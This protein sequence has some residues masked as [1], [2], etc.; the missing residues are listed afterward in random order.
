VIRIEGGIVVTMDPQRRVIPEG[1]VLLDGSRISAVGDASAGAGEHAHQIVDARGMAVLPG[2]VNSHTHIGSNILARGLL[3]DVMLFQWLDTLWKLKVN[4]THDDLF[5]AS[6]VGIAEMLLSG[7]TTYNEFFDGYDPLPG[8][9]AMGQFGMRAAAG[10][11]VADGGVYADTAEQSWRDIKRMG[12]LKAAHDGQADGRIHLV[13][14]PHAPYT[15]SKDLYRETRKAAGEHGL[16][17]HAHLAESPEETRWVRE[18]Y[19]QTSAE[20]FE[21]TGMLGPDVIAA[22]CTQLTPSDVQLLAK[23]GT[24][25]THC[26]ICNT[27]MCA[28]VLPLFEAQKA[29]ITVGLGTDGP[30]SNNSLDLLGEAKFAASL[31]KHVS[32]DAT[33]LPASEVLEMATIRSARAMGLDAEIGSLEVGKKADVILVDLRKANCSPLH[34][35]FNNLVYSASGANV[36]TVIVDGKIL[37]EDRKLLPFDEQAAVADLNARAAALAQKSLPDYKPLMPG[38][39]SS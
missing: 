29:G 24:S 27:R 11:C 28:G 39:V 26:P 20:L 23:H 4:F 35:V 10:W 30:A 9:E 14:A 5:A 17:I 22:H 13:I 32:G 18:Q 6:K 38:P 31:H 8:I 1:T 21:E 36:H 34:R 16:R 12:E 15:V 3:D 33:A 7:T 19:N 37:V 25:I 2:L